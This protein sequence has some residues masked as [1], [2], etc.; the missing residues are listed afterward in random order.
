MVALDVP[1]PLLSQGVG[2]EGDELFELDVPDAQVVNEVS[3]DPLQRTKLA[4]SGTFEEQAIHVPHLIR[5]CSNPR[6][7]SINPGV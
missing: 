2:I 7:C 3:E 5:L 1:V 4:S 6:T